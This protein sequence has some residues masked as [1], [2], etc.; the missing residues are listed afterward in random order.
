MFS[1]FKLQFEIIITKGSLKPAFFV[2]QL[3][4]FL[5]RCNKIDQKRFSTLHKNVTKI[6]FLMEIESLLK[7]QKQKF[8]GLNT[9]VKIY[10]KKCCLQ[11]FMNLKLTDTLVKKAGTLTD[12]KHD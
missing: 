6:F 2:I 4:Q 12:R 11:I 8:N 5:Q 1:F 9:H 10:L 3:K 7:I